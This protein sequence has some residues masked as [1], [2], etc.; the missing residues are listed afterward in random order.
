MSQQIKTTVACPKCRQKLDA[1][2]FRTIWGEYPENRELVMSDK[3][4][5]TTCPNC[6]TT[7]KWKFPLMYTNA[8]QQ[9]AVWWEPYPDPQI[10]SD[11]IDF[12]RMLGKKDYLATAPRIKDWEEFK[13][14]I[15]KYENGELK[16]NSTKVVS[17]EMQ[18]QMNGFLKHLKKQGKKKNGCLGI[19]LLFV[20][21]LLLS[22]IRLSC[23]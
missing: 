16:A 5:S 17:K 8:H 22:A 20:V 9:F 2:I 3:I 13:E 7:T 18:E 10:D 1:T 14:T 12:A 15:V 23:W 19:V 4:N 11:A 6:N 21:S